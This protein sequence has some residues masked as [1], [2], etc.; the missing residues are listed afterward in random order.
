MLGSVFVNNL[1]KGDMDAY[2]NRAWCRC[3]TCLLHQR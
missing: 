2:Q 1:I 3:A